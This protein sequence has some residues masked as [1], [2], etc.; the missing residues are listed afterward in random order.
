MAF[1]TTRCEVDNRDAGQM[2][3]YLEARIEA[4]KSRITELELE[5]K[6]LR[7]K[8]PKYRDSA[9]FLKSA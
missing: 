2:Y 7:L 8:F 6:A 9:Q 1:N 5:N 4:M 3:E